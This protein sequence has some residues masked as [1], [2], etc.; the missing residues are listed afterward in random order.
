MP[1]LE[2]IIKK[3]IQKIIFYK[4]N[5]NVTYM[6]ETTKFSNVTIIIHTVPCADGT[7]L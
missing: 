4:L 3:H 5:Q 2:N 1:L 6:L 7:G